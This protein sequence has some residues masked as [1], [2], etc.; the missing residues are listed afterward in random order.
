MIENISINLNDKTIVKNIKEELIFLEEPKSFAEDS[1]DVIAANVRAGNL[2]KYK[3]GDEKEVR[4]TEFTNEEKDAN[5]NNVET[6][7]VRIANTSTPSECKEEGF[8]QTACGFVIEFV[9]IITK[10]EMNPTGEYKGVQYD[11]GWNKD[12]WPASSMRSYVNSTIYD[13]LPEELRNNI[14][15]TY[16]VSGHG[17]DDAPNKTTTDKIYLLST[18]EVYEQGIENTIDY[19]TAREET[20][21]L[22]YYEIR[23][24]TTDSGKYSPVIKKY[25]G[26]DSFWW[27]RSAY[28]YKAFDFYYVSFSGGWYSHYT[29]YTGGVAVAFRL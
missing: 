25:N 12:G 13:A 10:H 3:V 8:S 28:S 1:W 2:S 29:N 4:L 14:K 21:Q 9:D 24:V 11:F 6:Y 17:S 5:G 19:D 15:D 20:R 27:L 16:V 7:T 26:N 22:D 18:K 23:G